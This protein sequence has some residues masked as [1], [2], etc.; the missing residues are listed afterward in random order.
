MDFVDPMWGPFIGLLVLVAVVAAA[1]RLRGPGS[2]PMRRAMITVGGGI[3]AV[4]LIGVAAEGC[5]GSADRT[6]GNAVVQP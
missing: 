1:V 6:P 2:L 5:S 4:V 3:V